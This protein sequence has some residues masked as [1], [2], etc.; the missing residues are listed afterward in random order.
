[1]WF[2]GYRDAP[3]QTAEKFSPDG[4]WFYTGDTAARDEEGHL[5]FSGRGDDIILMAGY[6][7]GPFEV[8]TVLLGHAAVAEVAVVGVPDEEYGEVVEAFVVPRPGI[9]AGD[10]L[11]AE[12][13]QLVRERYAKH[14]YPRQVHFVSE[15][16]KTSSGKTQRFLLR[17]QQA[18]PRSR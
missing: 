15:L 18:A 8:E 5:F 3:E 6:R 4:R 12:L 13:Q 7:I 1:M 2:K 11:A 14:A 17:P 9:E 16:P 10:A